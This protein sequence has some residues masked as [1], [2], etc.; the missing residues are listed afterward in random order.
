MG[1]PVHHE[2]AALQRLTVHQLRA[3]Y[4]AV[5]GEGTAAANRAWLVKR[6][7]YRLQVLA[8]GDLSERAR[9]RAA[10]LANDADLRLNPPKAE[11]VVPPGRI[12]PQRVRDQL[13]RRLPPP[14]QGNSN[15]P[16]DE[17][18]PGSRI[19]ALVISPFMT[20][21]FGV[22]HTSHDTTSILATIEHR[23]GL[24]ALGTRDQAVKDLS[25]VFT[26]VAPG[27]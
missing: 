13:D 3:R 16:H 8:E 15:G 17:W 19:P 12:T 11:A 9:R 14:G 20:L 22:D 6:I 10:E 27:K 5:Y 26:P 21:P 25:S 24:Q 23:W 18:G 1:T 7:A 4:A 2:I